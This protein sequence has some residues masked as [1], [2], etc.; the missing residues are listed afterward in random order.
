MFLSGILFDRKLI[1]DNVFKWDSFLTGIDDA[2]I[3]MRVTSNVH[4]K[5][6][7]SYRLRSVA[8]ARECA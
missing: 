2:K 6:P 8:Y 5:G 7:R 3:Q 4:A 1:Y